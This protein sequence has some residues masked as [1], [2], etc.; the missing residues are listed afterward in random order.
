MTCHVKW[1]L[2]DGPITD[3]VI[4]K[5]V[6]A[7]VYH[8]GNYGKYIPPCY[9][10]FSDADSVIYNLGKILDHDQ[11]PEEY[12]PEGLEH[13]EML[14]KI[15]NI[16]I[17]LILAHFSNQY[18]SG[19]PNKNLPNKDESIFPDRVQLPNIKP[20]EVT[21][22]KID[23]LSYDAAGRAYPPNPEDDSS[24]DKIYEFEGKYYELVGD[25]EHKEWSEVA[26]KPKN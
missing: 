6:E 16:C 13:R 18:N 3:E 24:W 21:I 1:M 23:K 14:L 2:A 10:V 11:K 17:P 4:Q 20:R 25:R 19:L 7:V 26:D 9:G 5:I 12:L 22:P 15:F 8:K